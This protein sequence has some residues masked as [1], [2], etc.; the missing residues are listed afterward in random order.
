MKPLILSTLLT[1]MVLLNATRMKAQSILSG[2]VQ[3]SDGKAQP[4]A[5]VKLLLSKTT[6]TTDEAGAFQI[7]MNIIGDTLMVSH[8]GFKPQKVFVRS[9]IRQQLVITLI[10]D[11][12][13]LEEVTISTGYYQVP[14]ERATGSF[15]HVDQKLINRTNSPDIISRLEGITSGL[16][17]NR[18]QVTGEAKKTPNLRIRGLATIESD[19]TPLIVLDNFPYEGDINNINPNDVE[20]VTLLKDAAAASIWGAR[21]GNGVIVITTKKGRHNQ[22]TSIALNSNFTIGGKP[23]LKYNRN[24]LPSQTVLDIE[25]ERFTANGYT[26]D[27]LTVLPDFVESLIRNKNGELSDADLQQQRNQL[28]AND[29]REEALKYLYRKSLNQQ[30]AINLNGGS[31]THTYFIS[32]GYDRAQDN[33]KGNRSSRVSLNARNSFT[34]L[35]NLELNTSIRY[36]DQN[37]QNNGITLSSLNPEGQQVSAY[38]RLIDANGTALSIPYR[39]RTAYLDNTGREGLL[40]WQYRPLDE[41]RLSDQ[42]AHSS[43]LLLNGEIRYR[44]LP[45]LGAQLSYQYLSSASENQNYNSPDSYYVRDWVN[46]F[47]QSDGTR[48]IPY[49]GINEIFGKTKGKAQSGRAQLNYSRDYNYRHQLSALA[50]AEV[51]EQIL[52]GFPLSRLYDFDRNLFTGTTS[53]DYTK[54]Y[55]ILP[56]GNLMIPAQGGS[57]DRYT[58]RY[59]SYFS[60]ASYSYKQHYTVSGSLRW[61][62]SNLFGVKTNQKGVPLW[63]VGGSW[64]LSRENFYHLKLLPYQRLRLSYGSSG[65]VNKYVSAFPTISF[66]MAENAMQVANLTSI[67]NPALRWEQVRTFNAGW[68]FASRNRRITG[69]LDYYRKKAKDLIGVDFLA[70]ST[71][72][73][74]TA[75]SFQNKINYAHMKTSGLDLQLNARIMN[76]TFNWDATALVSYVRNK[77]T[78]FNTNQNITPISYLDNS[79][80][81]TKG[82]SRDILYALPWHGLSPQTGKP[83]VMLD[84]SQSTDYQA[85]LNKVSKSDLLTAGVTIPPY[86]G[87]LRNTIGFRNFQLSALIIWKAGYVFRRTSISPGAEYFAS[88]AYHSDYMQRWKSPG[89]ETI[90]NIPSAGAYNQY[91]ARIYEYSSALI[92]RGDHIR[93]QDINL[94]Y[95]LESRFTEKFRVQNLRLFVNCANL[96]ILWRANNQRIDPEYPEASYPLS[97]TIAFGLQMNIQ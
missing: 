78:H 33:V 93:L 75:G 22:P 88:S 57:M 97:R 37:L 69:S 82:Q 96:G 53:F 11:A 9:T 44:I 21:A 55:P 4:Q 16:Q 65:N 41:Q 51:R 17:F 23:D 30:Y 48:I 34:L 81:P 25:Q 87:S 72:I 24:F 76:R 52:N 39:L 26:E 77:I 14:R 5:N 84:G 35:Q 63:S 59:L 47:T 95:T 90:T 19:E 36:T 60:N 62:G 71:G 3:N 86:Y 6:A 46:K 56:A 27:P 89:D 94:S 73:S 20:S 66:F 2:K 7:K 13:A 54:S 38:Q 29:I 91:Q 70:P 40:D 18:Q 67:G 15:S 49:N 92:T 31:P 85:Y 64:E 43:E 32:G 28:A 61:D 8:L 12:Q 42:T 68:D 83:I 80:P 10:Q 45:G 50:G 74:E 58:D 79:V 1:L